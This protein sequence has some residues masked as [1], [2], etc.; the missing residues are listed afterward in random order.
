[1]WALILSNNNN[2]IGLHSPKWSISTA[3]PGTI[4]SNQPAEKYAKKLSM[5]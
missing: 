3:F 5:K 1:M 4:L 2:A